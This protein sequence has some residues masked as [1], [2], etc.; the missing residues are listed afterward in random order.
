MI[1]RRP[2]LNKSIVF[3]D[4]QDKAEPK[5]DKNGLNKTILLR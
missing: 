5:L 4:K 1:L 2:D 3:I